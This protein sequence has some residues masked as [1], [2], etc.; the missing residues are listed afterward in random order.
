[1][2][3]QF[4]IGL[5]LVIMIVLGARL[6]FKP[7]IRFPIPNESIVFVG[8]TNNSSGEKLGIFSVTNNSDALID[9]TILPPQTKIDGTWR[10]QVKVDGKWILSNFAGRLPQGELKPHELKV[11]LVEVAPENELWRFHITYFKRMNPFEN[12]LDRLKVRWLKRSGN[13]GYSI[14][15]PEVAQ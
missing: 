10:N 8:Y 6:L 11:I 3:K 9:Y 14:L 13:E 5:V 2:K 4:V 1:V 15:S 12:K 7:R